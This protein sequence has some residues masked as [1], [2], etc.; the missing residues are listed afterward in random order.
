MG[1]ESKNNIENNANKKYDYTF[2]LFIT[3]TSAGIVQNNKD[4]KKTNAIFP[5]P[6]SQNN[7]ENA[8]KKINRY[9]ISSAIVEKYNTK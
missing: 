6:G 9:F 7:I 3:L 2:I 8:I 5:V 4:T 1:S